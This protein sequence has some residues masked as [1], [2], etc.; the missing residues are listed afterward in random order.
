VASQR[1]AVCA[2][3]Q[4]RAQF[5]TSN[6]RKAYDRNK[7]PA[8]TPSP[9]PYNEPAGPNAADRTKAL[10]GP[11]H[12]FGAYLMACL[13]KFIQQFSVYKDELTLYTAPDGVIPLC[14][15]LRDH[16]NTRFQQVVD[17]AGVD[18]PSRQK[19]FE[20]VYHFLSLV[21]NSRI[22]VKTYA[23][24][25]SPVPSI[26]SLFGGA[27]W[28]ER[29]AWDLYGIF[30]SGHPDLR[31]ILT[32]Y[33]FEGHPL[34]KDFPLTGYVEVRYDEEKKRVIQE[35]LQLSQAFRDLTG[36]LSPWEQI[37]PGVDVTPDTYKLPPQEQKKEEPK[38]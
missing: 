16:T 35:P 36:A 11:L 6:S 19:R 32:D 12:D 3:Q 31:R 38:K 21:H 29:E 23:D 1:A 7:P 28:Y 22:R 25:V 34:R 5:S 26:V 37:G 27:D 24:E 18:Y 17:I 2:Q 8:G 4:Q 13:P 9:S 14:T 10:Q 15:F 20:V 33:G 30:F